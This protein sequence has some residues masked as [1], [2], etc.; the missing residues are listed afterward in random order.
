MAIFDYWAVPICTFVFYVLVSL[1]IIAEEI[2]DPF[3][4]DPNDLPTQRLSENIKRNV[5]EIFDAEEN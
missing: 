2:E 5:I 4:T 3:G 1:E